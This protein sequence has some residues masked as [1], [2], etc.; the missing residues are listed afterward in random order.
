MLVKNEQLENRW[1]VIITEGDCEPWYFLEGWK[2]QIKERFT[3]NNKKDAIYK[4]VELIK[5][6]HKRFQRY[7]KRGLSIVCFWN[8]GE[9]VYCEACDDYLQVFHGIL[10]FNNDAVFN[11]KKEDEDIHV[12]LEV[13]NMIE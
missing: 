7:E 9:E 1:T 13:F 10:F 3:F 2:E 6:Y 11:F 8:E 4:Y 12:L 5:C